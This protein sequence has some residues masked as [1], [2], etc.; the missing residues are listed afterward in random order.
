MDTDVIIVGA[1]PTGLMLANQLV[2]RGVR[3]RIIDRHAGPARESRAL[4]VQARTLEIYSHLGIADQAVALGK[5]ADGA[6]L[7]AQGRRAARVPLGDIG[8][9]VSPYPY[10]L[11]LGQDDN[12]R[13]LGEALRAQG[14]AVEWNTE[15][16]GLAQ[17][18]DHVTATLK[19][20]DGT[21]SEVT[22]HGSPDATG[23]AARCASSAESR[24]RARRTSTCSS[25]PM[26]R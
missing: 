19:N 12:E 7:W 4:G 17:D 26:C 13:L 3:A 16:V 25:S 1:G 2:R 14:M 6:V 24:S 18:T 20:P 11:V 9:D 10:L 15:L 22:V 5:R 21:R 23:R 8:R